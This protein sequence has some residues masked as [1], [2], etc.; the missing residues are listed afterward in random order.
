MA[1]RKST[2]DAPTRRAGS[3]P[4]A[5]DVPPIHIPII[6]ERGQSARP[7]AWTSKH[8]RRPS[9]AFRRAQ[10]QAQENRRQ[11]RMGRRGQR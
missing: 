7:C 9:P 6:D 8:R 3:R 5:A 4:K 10:R 1:Y 2:H 11:A